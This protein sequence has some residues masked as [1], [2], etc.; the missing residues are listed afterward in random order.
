MSKDDPV[1]KIDDSG[2]CINVFYVE[3]SKEKEEDL[4]IPLRDSDEKDLKFS[5]VIGHTLPRVLL[6]RSSNLG[7]NENGFIFMR[8]SDMIEKSLDFHSPSSSKLDLFSIFKNEV[9]K[10]E[11]KKEK[12][13]YHGFNEEITETIFKLDIENMKKY[14]IFICLFLRIH[15]SMLFLKDER[16]SSYEKYLLMLFIDTHLDLSIE[17]IENG[18]Y[19]NH[20]LLDIDYNRHDEFWPI[21]AFFYPH[22]TRFKNYENMAS[23]WQYLYKSGTGGDF[24]TK[25]NE[26]TIYDALSHCIFTKSEIFTYQKRSLSQMLISTISEF[27][28]LCTILNSIIAISLLGNTLETKYYPNFETKLRIYNTFYNRSRIP[29]FSILKQWLEVHEKISLFCIRNFYL[30]HIDTDYVHDHYSNLDEKWKFIRNYIILANDDTRRFISENSQKS[31]SLFD[32]FFIEGIETVITKYYHILLKYSVKI[33]KT[34]TIQIFHQKLFQLYKKSLRPS[35]PPSSSMKSENKEEEEEEEKKEKEK[36]RNTFE[37]GTRTYG[38]ILAIVNHI[39]DS[40]ILHTD[41]YVDIYWLKTLGLEKSVYYKFLE[42]YYSY[43]FEYT[44][45]NSITKKIQ[46]ILTRSPRDFSVIRIFFEELYKKKS[47]LTYLLPENIRSLQI[48]ALRKKSNFL[49]WENLNESFD[50]SYYCQNCKKWANHVALPNSKKSKKHLG[51]ITPQ[52]SSLNALSG[53]IVCYKNSEIKSSIKSSKGREKKEKQEKN[54]RS[55][56]KNGYIDDENDD[57]ENDE[58]KENDIPSS[59]MVDGIYYEYYGK[60]DEDCNEEEE[61]ILKE[62]EKCNLDLLDEKIMNCEHERKRRLYEKFKCGITPLESINMIGVIKTLK[63]RMYTKCTI[64]NSIIEFDSSKVGMYGI[65]CCNHFDYERDY[66]QFLKRIERYSPENPKKCFY[67]NS[68]KNSSDKSKDIHTLQVL[69][70]QDSFSIKKIHI[71]NFHFEMV[72]DYHQNIGLIFPSMSTV[73]HSIMINP[74]KRK[75]V[76]Y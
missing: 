48:Q 10:E 57:D 4:L 23:M 73:R 38:Q 53:E 41:Q 24:Q 52:K 35:P 26:Y 64:C 55:S 62:L 47:N 8:F 11:E 21:L 16:I 51:S 25:N 74:D 27:P 39:H 1:I 42:C 18:F 49:P 69:D 12:K 30:Y 19:E 34:D 66:Y 67:C 71:C 59:L 2:K 45:E 40:G 70:E 46:P 28:D 5:K 76:K 7:G 31:D 14:A 44:P 6:R 33:N 60:E 15:F 61:E 37:I 72:S 56:K 17:I 63:N 43:V 3:G 22:D 9:R 68:Y 58:D 54:S 36:K 32:T 20:F 29:V 65:T 75:N 50:L 13:S